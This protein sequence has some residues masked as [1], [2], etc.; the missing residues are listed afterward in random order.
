ML[1]LFLSF[2][3]SAAMDCQAI[4]RK[5]QNM[6]E[7]CYI[8][9][10]KN[11]NSARYRKFPGKDWFVIGEANFLY[12]RTLG[13]NEVKF[14]DHTF[15]GFA[16]DLKNITGVDILPDHWAA[17]IGNAGKILL[18]PLNAEGNI[19]PVQ[20][21]KHEKMIGA[22]YVLFH[23]SGSRFMALVGNKVRLFYKELEKWSQ[24]YQLEQEFSTDIIATWKSDSLLY[25]V[26][27]KN[28]FWKKY[29]L[30]G[31]TFYRLPD[32]EGTFIKAVIEQGPWELYW[33]VDSLKFKDDTKKNRATIIP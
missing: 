16:T 28:R 10:L 32:G 31:N 17:V 21:I 15:A 26:D 3:A 6:P 11:V 25:V 5:G 14:G 22:T 20:V 12:G 33:D 13:Q 23:E 7:D 18:F 19:Y 8:E 1:L 27:V 9:A 24:V 29:Q 2:Q 4:A 30:T